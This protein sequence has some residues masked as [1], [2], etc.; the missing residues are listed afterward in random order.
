MGAVLAPRVEHR[1]L[2]D[3]PAP[4]ASISLALIPHSELDCVRLQEL[5]SGTWLGHTVTQE[6]VRVPDSSEQ[7][8][9]RFCDEGFTYID[10]GQSSVWAQT[11]LKKGLCSNMGERY[12]VTSAGEGRAPV[13]NSVAESKFEH[14]ELAMSLVFGD[15]KVSR[16]FIV[17]QYSISCGARLW[18]RMIDV[19]DALKLQVCKGKSY[20]WCAKRGHSW[21]ALASLMGLPPEH[22]RWPA[23]K[24]LHSPNYHVASTPLWLSIAVRG[25]TSLKTTGGAETPADRATWRHLVQGVVNRLVKSFPSFVLEALS[26]RARFGKSLAPWGIA[27]YV[28]MCGDARS[29]CVFVGRGQFAL[30]A[31]PGGSAHLRFRPSH[32]NSAQQRLP[33]LEDDS[34]PSGPWVWLP[35]HMSTPTGECHS[36]DGGNM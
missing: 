12:I 8:Q 9:L 2:E 17:R 27:E 33:K 6:R 30:V 13:V 18:W 29:E 35:G 16:D 3:M 20:L 23:S 36:P 14:N 11:L 28:R 7:W 22:F 31:G 34:L 21:S 1:D 19:F 4:P 15:P 5:P 10:D 25:V 26:V 24:D 32:L